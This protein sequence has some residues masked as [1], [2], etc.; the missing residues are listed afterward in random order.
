MA[1]LTIYRVTTSSGYTEF[2]NQVQAQ[3]YA[4]QTG[5]IL[6][7]LTKDNDPTPPVNTQLQAI[8]NIAQSSVGVQLS[9]LTAA[10]VKSLMAILLFKAGGVEFSDLTVRSLNEWVN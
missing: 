10:Q 7:T 6:T 3:T 5:G 8:K 1:I 4:T 2:T 9:N